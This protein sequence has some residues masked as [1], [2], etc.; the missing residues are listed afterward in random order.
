M[1]GKEK[2]FLCWHSFLSDVKSA[3]RPAIENYSYLFILLGGRRQKRLWT[4][5]F[6]TSAHRRFRQVRSDRISSKYTFLSKSTDVFVIVHSCIKKRGERLLSSAF[7]P[8]I[9]I[10]MYAFFPRRFF[11]SCLFTRLFLNRWGRRRRFNWEKKKFFLNFVLKIFFE[12]FFEV[13]PCRSILWTILL[14]LFFFYYSHM[15][16]YLWVNF[17]LPLVG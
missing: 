15:S 6:H 5:T 16:R 12:N 10:I 14:R 13:R 9:I 1:G 17:T 4:M 11:N 3:V 2:K 8:I 7:K